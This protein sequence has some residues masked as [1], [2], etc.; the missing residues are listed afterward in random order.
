MAAFGGAELPTTDEEV[1]R[2][3]RIDDLSLD[4][5]APAGPLADPVVPPPAR[6]LVDAVPDPSATVLVGNGRIVAVRLDEAMAAK[7]VRVGPARHEGDLVGLAGEGGADA[8]LLLHDAFVAD[9]VVVEVPAGVTVPGP[10][11]VVHVAGGPG[12]ATFPH[13]VVRAG[14][15][16]EVST[17]EVQ[18]S[19]GDDRVLVVPVTEILV[20]RAARVGHVTVQQLGP[21]AWQIGAQASRVD[22]AASLRT[23][24]VGFGGDFARL[25]TDC[26]MVGR[27]AT[28][29]LDAVYFG[30]GDQTLDF[31][32]FQD[33]VAPDCTSNLLFKGAG[34]GRSRSVYTGMIH[35]GREARGTNAFQTNRNV[36]LSP[37]A[38]AES[39]PNLVIENNDV[40]CSHA[41][42]VGPVDEDQRFYLE[43]RGVPG[44]D[45]ERLIVT[46]FFDEV[47]ARLPIPGIVPRLRATVA[48]KFERKDA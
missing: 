32:T 35:V 23:T 11:V 39:V 4:D 5:F 15:D 9:P 47:L 3:S 40:R 37:G 41:S 25:R 45:A 8:L 26:R 21:G 19:T 34:G 29:E 7:G 6:A 1:W 43:S 17:L 42:A 13:L 24:S 33:H 31:R 14:E 30:E 44:E 36:K 28:G 20:G 38:W 16:S 2:Y 10:V 22:A 46:G 12:G 27:G 48:A 18:A